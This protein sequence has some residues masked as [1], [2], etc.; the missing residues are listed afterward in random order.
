MNDKEREKGFIYGARAVIEA[1]KSGKTVEKVLI[2]RDSEGELV[3][4]LKEM[5]MNQNVPIQ[6]VPLE[7][8]NRLTRMNHQGIIAF[9]SPVEFCTIEELLPKLFEE[10]KTPFIL[11]LDEITDVRNFGAIIRTAECCGVHAIVFPSKGSAGVSEDMV[12]TSAGAIFHIPMC[13]C[14]NLKDAVNFIR[15]SGVKLVA[16]TEKATNFYTQ[17][18]Y[19]QPIAIVLGSEERGVTPFFIKNADDSVKIPIL[20]TIDSLNVSVAAAVMM[21]EVVRQ[22]NTYP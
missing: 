21:Y 9:V 20:G 14:A 13:R 2:K 8:L 11:V 17:V 4:E 10:G 3:K 5:L 19:N 22:R 6:T 7:A 1:M 16:S 15:A 12:K 18:D